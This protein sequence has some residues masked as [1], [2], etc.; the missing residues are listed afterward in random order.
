MCSEFCAT[1]YLPINLEVS[2]KHRTANVDIPGVLKSTGR[3]KI[4]EFNGEP[5]HV[6]LARPSGSFEFAYAELGLGTSSVTGD[7]EMS[8][9]DTWAHFCVH[10]FDQAGLVRERPR[11]T[12]WLDA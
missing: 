1:L 9:E 5:F 8:Y 2:F 6:A 11:L 10:H 4:N 3:P 12:K 7:I